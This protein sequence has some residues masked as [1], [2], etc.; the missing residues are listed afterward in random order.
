LAQCP[1]LSTQEL[2]TAPTE[3]RERPAAMFSPQVD[4]E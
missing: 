2:T 3:L 4:Q 1:G